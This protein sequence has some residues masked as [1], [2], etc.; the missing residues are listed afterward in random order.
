MKSS[1]VPGYINKRQR[2]P[3]GQSSM[4]NPER[5]ATLQPGHITKTNKH[6]NTTQKPT[7]MSNMDPTETGVNPCELDG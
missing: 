6:K 1:V 2:K 3:K 5:H 4:D 7:K